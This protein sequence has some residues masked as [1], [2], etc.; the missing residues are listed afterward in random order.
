MFALSVL[1]VAVSL[2]VWFTP[3]AATVQPV[4]SNSTLSNFKLNALFTDP[5]L[6]VGLP[7][8]GFPIT[9]SFAAVDG[10][11]FYSVLSSNNF[12]SP[13]DSY[14]LNNGA[15]ELTSSTF[16]WYTQNLHVNAGNSPAFKSD[17]YTSPG[18]NEWCAMP[19]DSNTEP[20]GQTLPPLQLAVQNTPGLFSLCTNS[21]ANGRQDLVFQPGA[22]Y[23]PSISNCKKVTLFPIPV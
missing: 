2:A 5:A 19:T 4:C 16:S 3:A 11:T 17:G 7:A 22:T 21:S 6:N 12:W 20:L 13:W 9:G 8:D 18:P 23:E 15:L 10:L 14:K 1:P